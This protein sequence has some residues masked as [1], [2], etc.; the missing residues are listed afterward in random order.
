[1]TPAQRRVGTC[2]AIFKHAGFPARTAKRYP[3]APCPAKKP[4]AG[5]AKKQLM[6]T[7]WTYNGIQLCRCRFV[8]ANRRLPLRLAAMM[9]A[10]IRLSIFGPDCDG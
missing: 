1:M 9:R 2:L 5:L 7:G 4:P 10:I 8:Y 3:V 6:R